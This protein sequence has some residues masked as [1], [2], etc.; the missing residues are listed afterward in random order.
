MDGFRSKDFWTSTQRS[1]SNWR[2]GPVPTPTAGYFSAGNS[3][4]NRLPLPGDDFTPTVPPK[5]SA[6]RRTIHRHHLPVRVDLVNAVGR[7]F[8]QRAIF[9]F[10]LTEQVFGPFAIGG[11]DHNDAY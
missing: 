1:A 5:L 6:A 11:F 8:D 4:Q 10:T 7:R 9:L 3:T 2:E